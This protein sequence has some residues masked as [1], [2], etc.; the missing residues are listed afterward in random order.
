MAEPRTDLLPDLWER[1]IMR[2]AYNLWRTPVPGGWLVFIDI[3]HAPGVP[4]LAFYPDPEYQWS[5][6]R[7]G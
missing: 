3:P 5:P 7:V 1:V 6:E 2:N 4:S